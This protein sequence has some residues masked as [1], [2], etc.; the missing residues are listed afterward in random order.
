MRGTPHEKRGHGEKPPDTFNRNGRTLAV[1]VGEFLQWLAVIHRSPDTV[2]SRRWDLTPFIAWAEERSLFDPRQFTGSILESYQ[3]YLYHYRKK[4]DRPLGITTQRLRLNAVKLFFAWLCRQHVL[5]ANP[6]SE[7]VMPTRDK[8][9]PVEPLT[10][11]QVAAVLAVPDLN[12]P[13]GL[14]D[15]AI[16]ELFYSTGIRRTELLRLRLS[17]LNTEKQVLL[18][19]QGKG[20]K[21]RIVPVGRRALRWIHKYLDD[22]RPLLLYDVAQD[23]LFLTGFGDPFSADAL[24]EKVAAYIERAAVGRKGSC[25][26]LRHSCATHMLEGGA[27]IRFIQQLLGHENLDTTAVY[28]KVSIL[29]LQAVHAKTHPAETQESDDPV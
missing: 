16:L 11:S 2:D 24:S 3:R 13:L 17:D 1:Y 8:R 4:N 22:V 28:T 7:L 6:A 18:I 15:R 14:R 27:D 5:D 9:L 19:R 21:D 25:H 12:N 10:V 20:R 23:A 29:Q 26:L